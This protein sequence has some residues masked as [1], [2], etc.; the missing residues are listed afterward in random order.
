MLDTKK[1]LSELDRNELNK[2]F[3]E[4]DIPSSL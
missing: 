4:N 2:I 1:K 3:K